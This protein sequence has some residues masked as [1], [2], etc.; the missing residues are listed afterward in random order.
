[1]MNWWKLC[2]LEIMPGNIGG[3][4]INNV[5]FCTDNIA[6]MLCDFNVRVLSLYVLF[7][8]VSVKLGRVRKFSNNDQTRILIKKGRQS[9][10]NSMY[11][12]FN[13]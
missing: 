9:C 13:H 11:H 12:S 10:N 1:M 4:F 3:Q 8:S 2:H 6:I 7:S 5:K